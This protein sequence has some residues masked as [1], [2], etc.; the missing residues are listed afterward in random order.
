MFDVWTGFLSLGLA[1]ALLLLFAL[2]HLVFVGPRSNPLRTLPGPPSKLF[3]NSHMILTMDPVRSPRTHAQFV[4]EYGRS[5]HIRGP[6]PPWQSRALITSLI[7]CGMLAAEGQVHKRQRRVATPAFSIQNLRALVP[8][9]FSKGVT[10]KNKWGSLIKECAKVGRITRREE[11]GRLVIG[12]A[13][14]RLMLLALLVTISI[15]STLVVLCVL[16]R[17]TGFD[18]QFNAV[19]NGE[20][21]LFRAYK[22]MFEIGVSQQSG[23]WRSALAVYIP[24]H[25]VLFP[26]Q[27]E[28]HIKKCRAVI[29][30][31]AGG[32]IQ[33][34]K[35]KIS[36]AEKVGSTYQA[37][38]L[39]T[40]LLKSNQSVDIAPSQRIS[41]EDILNNINTFMFA[42]SD[43]TSL[44]ITWTLLLMALFPSI[45]SKLRNECL[46]VLP[47][48]P[49]ESLS[50]EDIESL[51]NIISELPYLDKV[52][53]ESLRL[54]PPLH[55]SIRVAT[56]DDEIPTSSPIKFRQPDGTIHEE[57]RPIK[58]A[59]G[60][61]IH[62]PVEAF[63]LDKE[64][65]GESAWS[66]IPDRWDNLPEAVSSQPGLYSNLLTFSAGPRSCIGQKFSIIEMKSFLFIL[67]SNF[68]FTQSDDKIGKANV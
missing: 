18:Y 38:D 4:K 51:Y 29:E 35:R 23:S 64:I 17:S 22:E 5:V 31:I 67:L 24:Y 21:E 50:Q 28:R 54:I 6:L 66:F 39:L 7:G 61:F 41:D 2:V 42:G 13:E 60:S 32:L 44:S 62:I 30:R 37:R 25:D 63:N 65:W 1:L 3:D 12:L 53:R 40:L 20:N 8:L 47:S 56:R 15:P 19:E 43:T 48:A 52:A 46:S 58:I 49:L 10:L 27:A 33:E 34:K 14:R 11:V 36:E 68:V 55:S 57:T 9:V 26:D 45:Q 59:K 16:S